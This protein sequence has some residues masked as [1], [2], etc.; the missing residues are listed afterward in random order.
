MSMP[1][2]FPDKMNEVVPW[3]RLVSLVEAHYPKAGNGRPPIGRAIVLRA[4]FVQQLF[5]QSDAGVK[6]ALYAS[7][8]LRHFG[9]VNLGTG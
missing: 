3:T 4:Y 6:D 9:G 1:E 5:N 2:Q 7:A 8:S